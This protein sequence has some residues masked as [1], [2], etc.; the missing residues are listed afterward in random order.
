M[1]TSGE[2]TAIKVALISMVSAIVVALI[3]NADKFMPRAPPAATP[4]TVVAAP[5]S[6]MAVADPEPPRAE[7][8]VAADPP[9]RAQPQPVV[10]EAPPTQ[11]AVPDAAPALAPGDRRLI[12]AWGR[13]NDGVVRRFIMRNDTSQPM[14][15]L[16]VSSADDSADGPDRLGGVAV[17]PGVSISVDA[18]DG[19]K[20]CTYDMRAVFADGRELAQGSFDVCSGLNYMWQFGGERR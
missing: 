16:F 17:P 19:S 12:A 3:A 11:R 8:R 13:S 15:R 14:V 18:D 6:E 20:R 7:P 10:R 2:A 5:P 1:A 9:P 4:P